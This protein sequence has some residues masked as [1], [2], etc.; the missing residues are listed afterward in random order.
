VRPGAPLG[1]GVGGG[2]GREAP[3][4]GRGEA[5]AAPWAAL[6]ELL[7][8]ELGSGLAGAAGSRA[9][10]SWARAALAW[11]TPSRPTLSC[12]VLPSSTCAACTRCTRRRRGLSWRWPGC[13]TSRTGSSSAH[14]RCAPPSSRL[15]CAAG[16]GSLPRPRPGLD[17]PCPAPLRP[18]P[19]NRT[20]WQRRRGWPR[21]RWRPMKCE[22]KLFLFSPRRPGCVGVWRVLVVLHLP[23]EPGHPPRWGWPG[24]AAL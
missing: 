19:A 2:G 12:L 6:G 3:C 13:A 4:L 1:V 11:P 16:G 14:R 22:R 23:V 9:R 5:Q 20:L 21:R 24:D 8:A 15:L 17:L 7:A 10:A 18:A